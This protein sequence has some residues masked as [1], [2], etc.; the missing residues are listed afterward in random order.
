MAVVYLFSEMLLFFFELEK[1]QLILIK[2]NTNCAAQR[3]KNNIYNKVGL[4]TLDFPGSGP[5]PTVVELN[6]YPPKPDR[7]SCRALTETLSG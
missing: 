6:K 3:P 7:T 2:S 5:D 4:S 1:M